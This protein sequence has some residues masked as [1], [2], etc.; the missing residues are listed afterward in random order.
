MPPCIDLIT[1]GGSENK[2]ALENFVTM[3]HD[4]IKK[5]V[6]QTDISFSNSMI[7]AVNKRLK[8]DYLFTRDFLD[9]EETEKFLRF[10]I[11][12]YNNKP[13]GSLYGLTPKEVFEGM[14]PDKDMFTE[15]INQE[16]KKRKI[17]NLNQDCFRCR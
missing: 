11:D 4:H 2:G 16:A 17:I 12:E 1:D 13:H 6:A 8:Y 3:S 14:I 10:A 15:R 5:L 9:F 7:E